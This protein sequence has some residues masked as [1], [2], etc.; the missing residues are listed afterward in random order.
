MKYKYA[1]VVL[2]IKDDFCVEETIRELLHQG[3]SKVLI[4]SPERYWFDEAIQSPK[5]CQEL[6]D[7]CARTGAAFAQAELRADV[8]EHV[9]LY[10]EALYRNRAIDILT[11]SDA[12]LDYLLTVDADEFWMPGTLEHID[13]IAGP[14]APTICLPGIPVLGVPGLPVV[15]AKDNILV[16]TDRKI[17]F[18]WGR[19]TDGPRKMGTLPV[20]HFSSTRRT[21]QEVIDKSVK[22]AHYPDKTYDFDGWIKNTLPNVHVGMKNAH[23]Y[24]SEVNIWPEVRAWTPQELAVIPTSLHRYLKT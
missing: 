22:S 10:T 4:M 21:L 13:S 6:V 3:V 2:A 9:A 23:M 5:D 24:K 14:D 12:N 16:A 11:R 20:I 1:A 15:G 19:S 7:I 18:K 17:R 8:E